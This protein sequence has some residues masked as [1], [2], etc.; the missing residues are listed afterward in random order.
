MKHTTIRTAT[1]AQRRQWLKAGAAASLAAMMP[2]AFAKA[3]WPDKYIKMVVAFPAGGPTDTA[4][5]ILAQKLSERLGQQVVIEN[6]PGAS[7]SIGTA[8][9]I[10]SAADGYNLSMFGMPALLA[11]LMYKNNAYDVKKDFL[12]VAT[13]YVLP[14]AIVINPNVVPNVDTLPD[15]I[16]FAKA[17]KTP[18]N[19][20]SSGTG[21]FGHL[22]MEQLK[23]LGGFDMQH[24]PYKGSA[25]AVSDLLGGQIGVMFADV[26][27]A[28]P[29]I[30][31]G[32]LKA[33]ALSSQNAKVLLP[34]VKTVSDQGFP[35]FDFDSWGGLIVPLDTP[36]SIVDRLT[37]ETRDIVT[38]DKELQQKLVTAGAIASF[39]DG[40][41]MQARLN[42]DYDRWSAIVKAKGI[43]AL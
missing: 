16:R 7:G 32:K 36:Q 22:A 5:R 11:P 13:V 6:K 4:A 43:S 29:H 38:T 34:G 25:P 26:V 14:M 3:G 31:A 2:A 42:K 20:T 28:L 10:K 21:S 1:S 33:I 37:S 35:N 41:Q 24:V 12:S 9:F 30:R 15:L 19:Y 40:K 18:L 23:D 17:S 8:S 27:A 39:Q